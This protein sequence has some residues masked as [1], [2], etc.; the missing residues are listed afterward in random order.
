L[1][2][3]LIFLLFIFF[4]FSQKVLPNALS[5]LDLATIPANSATAQTLF[6]VDSSFSDNPIFF[7]K[8]THASINYNIYSLDREQKSLNFSKQYKK[9]MFSANWE[10]FSVKDLDHLGLEAEKIGNLN[11]LVNS[12]SLGFGTKIYKDFFAGFR[13]QKIMENMS[14]YFNKTYELDA[15]LLHVYFQYNIKNFQM[16]FA[17][18]NLFS[19]IS[20]GIENIFEGNIGIDQ[21]VEKKNIFSGKYL[22]KEIQN[23]KNTLFFEYFY[24]GISESVYGVGVETSFFNIFSI[25]AGYNQ[26]FRAGFGIWLSQI[27]SRLNYAYLSEKYSEGVSHSFS[28]SVNL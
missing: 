17:V 8:K 12:F 19:D 13:A 1:K 15:S 18:K 5:Y 10:N 11:Y 9:I 7:H 22:L 25:R 27:N 14:G 2:K 6:S 26:F 4:T 21:K 23:I 3:I 20:T 28:W 24:D 16:T